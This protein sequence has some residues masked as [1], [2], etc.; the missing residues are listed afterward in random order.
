L[1]LSELETQLAEL[2]MKLQETEEAGQ[3]ALF[4]KTQELNELV[5][6]SQTQRQQHLEEIQLKNKTIDDLENEMKQN[7]E[8]FDKKLKAKN[9]EISGMGEELRKTTERLA[10]CLKKQESVEAEN[11][12][13]QSKIAELQ[14]KIKKLTAEQVRLKEL[15]E[16]AK[17]I[18]TV[19]E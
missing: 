2:Q 9:T 7:T 18:V 8:T 17:S 15:L 4:A 12:S 3:K 5:A 19:A 6:D 13:Q 16:T 10:A 1:K 11:L 14:K